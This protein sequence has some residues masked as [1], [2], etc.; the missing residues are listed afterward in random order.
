MDWCVH[1]AQG[2][3]LEDLIYPIPVNIVLPALIIIDELDATKCAKLQPSKRHQKNVLQYS[4][5]DT[6]SNVHLEP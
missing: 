3:R 6:A 2:R 1:G 4:L 5:H